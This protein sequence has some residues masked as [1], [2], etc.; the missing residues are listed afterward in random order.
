M[1]ASAATTE[2]RPAH[3]VAS[4]AARR[5][6][7]APGAGPR[8]RTRLRTPDRLTVMLFSVAA[9]LIVLALL[10]GQMRSQ[11]PHAGPRTMVVRRVYSTKIVETVIGPSRAGGSSVTQSVS[12]S[13]G[14]SSPAPVV[15]TR[16]S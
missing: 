1:E 12:S 16:T 5:P 3:R 15:A 4:P 10:A 2:R 9:F 13:A 11:I 6:A 14:A 7:A 8:P